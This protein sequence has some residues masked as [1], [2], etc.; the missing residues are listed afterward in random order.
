[1]AADQFD[2]I[3]KLF[4]NDGTT[5]GGSIPSTAPKS[6]GPVVWGTGETL[7]SMPSRAPSGGG[8]SS[9]LDAIGGGIKSLGM[10]ALE[11]IN[12]PASFLRSGMKEISDTIVSSGAGKTALSW[13]MSAGDLS[14]QEAYNRLQDQVRRENVSGSLSEFWK[15]GKGGYQSADYLKDI[16][17]PMPDNWAGKAG[18]FALDVATDPLVYLSGGGAMAGKGFSPTLKV[19]VDAGNSKMIAKAV[20][21]AAHDAGFAKNAIGSFADDAINQLI[22]N[23]EKMGRG[24]LTSGALKK[25][26]IDAAMAEKLG[27]GT[28]QKRVL[29]YTVGGKASTKVAEGFE[30]VKGWAKS[31]LRGTESASKLREAFLT[32]NAGVKNYYKTIYNETASLGEKAAASIAKGTT[33]ATLM[34][35]RLFSKLAD[36][37]IAKAFKETVDGKSWFKLSKEQ[38]I[39]ATHEIEAGVQSAFHDVPRKQLRQIFDEAKAAGVDVGDLGT[40][41]LPH[42]LTEDAVNLA[43]KNPE[44]DNIITKNLFTEEGFQKTRGLVAGSEFLGE[45]LVEGTIKEINDRMMAKYGIKLFK[46]DIREIMPAYVNQVA[47]A[48]A[49]AEQIKMFKQLGLAPEMTERVAKSTTADSRVVA[50]IEALKKQ[51]AKTAD[52]EVVQL[53]NGAKVRRGELKRMRGVLIDKKKVLNQRIATIEHTIAEYGR[54]KTA[55]ETAAAAVEPELLAAQEAVTKWT[56]VA[57]AQRGSFRKSALARVREAEKV[58]A[59][60]Q[61]RLE[62]LQSEIDKIFKRTDLPISGKVTQAKS[63][64]DEVR[65]LRALKAESRDLAAQADEYLLKQN[66]IGT[67]SVGTTG[68]IAV[69]DASERVHNLV[70]QRQGLLD[71]AESVANVFN[72]ATANSEPV[73]AHLREYMSELDQAIN[74]TTGM[75]SIGDRVS[76]EA[77]QEMRTRLDT[78]YQVLSRNGESVESKLIAS[79]E[80]SAAASDLAALQLKE[81]GGLLEDMLKANMDMKF[82][83]I[84]EKFTFPNMIKLDETHQIPNWLSDATKVAW[85]HEQFKF[86]GKWGLKVYKFFKNYAILKPG[87]HVRNGYSAMFNMYLEAG[88]QSIKSIRKFTQFLHMTEKN[89]EGFMVQATKRWGKEDAQRLYEA[90]QSGVVG[91]GAGQAAGEFSASAFQAG[92]LNPLSENFKPLRWSRRAGEEVESVIRGA[93][94]Y[95]VLARGGNMDQAMDIISKWHFNYADL[96]SWDQKMK[97]VM[98]FWTFFS[99]NLALQSQTF[100]TSLAKFNR[101]IGNFERAMTYGDKTPK[102]VPKYI[103]D[104]RGI[105]V[106]GGDKPQFWMSDLPM[107]SG[108]ESASNVITPSE[109]SKVA[110][111]T[112]PWIKGPLEIM[113]DR[114]TFTGASTKDQMAELFGPLG[115]PVVEKRYANALQGFIPTLG[116]VSRLSGETGSQFENWLAWLGYSRKS[117]TPQ[118]MQ[119]EARRRAAEAESAARRAANAKKAG[120]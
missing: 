37:R 24:A 117:V 107:L 49:R 119:A 82:A 114:S 99:R 110:S 103:Q 5:T 102:N 2:A 78:V 58:V 94:A 67:R 34:S 11:A 35:Y 29:K 77:A 93:H 3:R 18:L 63:A 65:Q 17:T 25:A 48:V 109:W 38:G 26:G 23:A 98:P 66:P 85:N 105:M 4:G 22:V 113:F 96:G 31:G 30:G 100:V 56:A 95:D 20:S 51:I 62:F 75:R 101:T 28:L 87:F 92:G 45:P 83:D 60:K 73:L 91:T 13:L 108:L 46:D 115:G 19:A 68:D 61:A 79:V 44:V 57:K 104:A 89:P 116:Q 64:V 43:K 12:L 71:E 53:A 55:L 111:N 112:A 90:W 27:I 86:F 106:R 52:D 21:T 10:G 32:G 16:G 74:A 118:M 76:K 80:A 8:D 70:L 33:N 88:A 7:D 39:A 59:E 14:Q 15:Q 1:M 81:S 72:F 69:A 97:M 36:N 47:E 6:A 54:R 42:K 50:K 120:A 84:Q 9:W 40:N 41:Y